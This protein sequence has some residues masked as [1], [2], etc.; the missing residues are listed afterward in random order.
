MFEKTI[1]ILRILG[2]LTAFILLAAILYKYIEYEVSDPCPDNPLE[3]C[4]TEESFNGIHFYLND[5]TSLNPTCSCLA[6]KTRI[7]YQLDL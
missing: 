1:N 4:D 7:Y 2:T 5:Y 3:I 6:N